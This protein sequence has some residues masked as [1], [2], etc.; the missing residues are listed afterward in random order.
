MEVKQNNHKTLLNTLYERLYIMKLANFKNTV[1]NTNY[2]FDT[3]NQVVVNRRTNKPMA[4][5]ASGKVRLSIN[6]ERNRFSREEIVADVEVIVKKERQS[7]K[8]TIA[9]QFRS[10]LAGLIESGKTKDEARVEMLEWVSDKIA[11]K[12]DRNIYFNR[13][14]KK[15]SVNP[16]KYKL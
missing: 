1:I 11:R 6:G 5:E 3:E 2:G 13:A 7:N 4:W 10:K 8:D 9:T 15:V 14:Y 16:S 12:S